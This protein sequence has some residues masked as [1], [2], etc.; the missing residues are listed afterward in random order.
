MNKIKYVLSLLFLAN[1][2]FAM[3]QETKDKKNYEENKKIGIDFT[4]ILPRE[5]IAL[6]ILHT[7][8]NSDFKQALKTIRLFEKTC[9]TMRSVA[10]LDHGINKQMKQKY[11]QFNKPLLE[12]LDKFFDID[13]DKVK[14]LIDNGCDVNIQDIEGKTP[15]MKAI[16]AN[17][18][19]LVQVLLNKMYK[20]NINMQDYDGRTAIMLAICERSEYMAELLISNN[21]DLNLKDKFGHTALTWA[22]DLM[23][24]KQLINLLIENGLEINLEGPDG[25]T[26]LTIA[27]KKFY[28][29]AEVIIDSL[30]YKGADV[31]CKNF[32]GK[33]R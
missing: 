29:D 28:K 18:E 14:K 5:I 3:E 20:T 25:N 10:Y 24:P 22:I 26:A 21:P 11:D 7:I 9:K 17:N 4:K 15:L 23:V 30:I 27:S 8:N 32:E 31:D 12:E 19:K 1:S 13:C 2:V 33:Q 6:T 16:K